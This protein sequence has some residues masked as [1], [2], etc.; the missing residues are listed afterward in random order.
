MSPIDYL[1]NSLLGICVVFFAL[2]LLMG[3]IK[4]MTFSPKKSEAPVA[5]TTGDGAT[6]GSAPGRIWCCRT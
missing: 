6:A 1:I 4:I 2:I 5:A 3:I